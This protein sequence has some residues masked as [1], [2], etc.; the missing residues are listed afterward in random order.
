LTRT[1]SRAK[2]ARA[3]RQLAAYLT[4]LGFDARRGQQ[5]SG[6]PDSP[7]VVCSTLCNL[8]I[9]AKHVEGM[10]DGNG[11]MDA[12][13]SQA[14]RDAGS[15]QPVVLWRTNGRKWRLTWESAV[16]G[17]RVTVT[18]DERIR[19][20]LLDL[21]GTEQAEPPDATT[22]PVCGGEADNGFSR[23]VPPQPYFCSVCDPILKPLN[24]DA[25]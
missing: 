14:R 25:A 4:Q 13:L 23:D 16:Y 18:G 3:E 15:K 22:C 7:D 17:V 10:R 2:G 6:S 20:V 9:E 8:H 24:G 11:L 12:A 21:N 1:N 5:F 19:K